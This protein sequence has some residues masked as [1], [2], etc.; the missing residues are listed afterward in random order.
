[1]DGKDKHD[2]QEQRTERRTD[3]LRRRAV[4]LLLERKQLLGAERLVV[5][6]RGRLD[7][8]LQVRAGGL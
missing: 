7:E 2:H 3:A 6:L 8:V 4:G 1:M 5:D